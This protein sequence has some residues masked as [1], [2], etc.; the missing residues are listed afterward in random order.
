MRDDDLRIWLRQRN[1][2]WRPALDRTAWARL[3]PPLRQAAALGID[4]RPRVLEGVRSG[5]LYIVRGP[6]RVG[7]SVALK[8]FAADLLARPEVHPAQ[9]IYMSLDDFDARTLRRA[10]SLARTLTAAADTAAAD[11]RGAADAGAGAGRYWL[12]DEVTAVPEWPA[13]IKSA[14]DDTPFAFDTVVL[15]GSSAHGLDEARR[16]LGAGRV[17]PATDPFRLLLP[18]TFRDYLTV[19]GRDLP[20][21]PVL[22]ATLRQDEVTTTALRELTFLVDDLDLAWQDYCEVGGF[23]RA[24]AEH[25]RDGYV[26]ASFATDVLDWLAPDVTPG[27]P[28]ESVL[29]LL[30]TLTARMTSPLNVRA[31]AEAAGLSRERL[32]T[33]L[34]RL[35]TTFATLACP[36]L[37]DMGQPI[38][39]AQSKVYPLD[40]LLAHLPQLVEPA[41]PVPAMSAVS[42]AVLA[43]TMARAVDAMQPGRLLEGRA[44]GYARTGG[45]EVDLAPVPT[46]ATGSE[47]WTPPV[48]SKWVSDGWRPDARAIERRYGRGFVATKNILD[49]SH[50]SWAVPAGALALLLA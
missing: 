8:R 38:S 9:V 1:P 22:G 12:I 15:T 19:T 13:I 41:F 3:D 27:D 24:V 28:P 45:G 25:R 6:R 48:E 50:P 7:K 17:G 20:E 10:L 49:L 30:S 34:N 31:T 37:D 39:G 35:Q 21:V 47:S 4:Y 2:W 46:G 43:A 40:P 29:R 36:Q 5:G 32:A 14:R 16:A 11:T 18:M 44:V 26:S 42:E 23:P 33:R